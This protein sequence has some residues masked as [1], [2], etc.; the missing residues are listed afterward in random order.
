[1][2]PMYHD[3]LVHFVAIVNQCRRNFTYHL[4]AMP[5]VEANGPI[6]G[7]VDV[8]FELAHANFCLLYTSDA[9]DE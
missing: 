4:E 3:Q 1:M 9:A 2:S 6:V 5:L 8:Q 7:V